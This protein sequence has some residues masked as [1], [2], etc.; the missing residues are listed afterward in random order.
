MNA[1]LHTPMLLTAV[2]L[3][4]VLWRLY[5]RLR[6][7]VGRQHLTPRRPWIIVILYPLLTVFL[8]LSAATQL[9][10][11]AALLGGA[12]TGVGL[13]VWA[14][15]LTRFEV[16]PAGLYYTPNT[17]IGIALSLLFLA[18]VVYRL[19]TAG[20]ALLLAGSHA[21]AGLA[22]LPP[23]TL[24]TLGPLAGYYTTY[25]IGLLRWR[26]RVHSRQAQQP[27]RPAS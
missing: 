5:R 18:R 16:T 1:P 23:L 26:W 19:T 14:F 22:P 12:A 4:L 11:L 25:S 3:G 15:R 7:A 6:H 8:V 21:G 13:G 20:P 17:H 9:L 2:F 24:L 27:T 10:A